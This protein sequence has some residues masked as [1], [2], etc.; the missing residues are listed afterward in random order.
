M[1][2]A[3]LYSQREA[4]LNAGNADE[5]N[6]IDRLLRPRCGCGAL[7][8]AGRTVARGG[9]YWRACTPCADSVQEAA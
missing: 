8:A 5:Y 3:D 7:A 1:A 9:D 6:R 4:A 2:T